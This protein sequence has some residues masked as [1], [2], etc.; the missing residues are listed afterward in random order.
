MEDM[1]VPHVMNDVFFTPRKIPLK[2][3]VDISIRS[4]P[5]REGQEGG[6][7]DDIECF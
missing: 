2:F 4:V 7:L 3:C 6:Y 5:G 1:V